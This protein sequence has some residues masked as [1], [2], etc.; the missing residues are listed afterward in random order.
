M[1]VAVEVAFLRRVASPRLHQRISILAATARD[2]VWGVADAVTVRVSAGV[3]G[4]VVAFRAGVPLVSATIV[5]CIVPCI[6]DEVVVVDG[7]VARRTQGNAVVVVRCGIALKCVII[8]T[9]YIDATAPLF[10]RCVVVLEG[11]VARR[12][13]GDADATPV[14]RYIVAL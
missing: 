8:R 1:V 6:V 9:F 2:W 11:V 7:V 3:V 14:A 5:P 13:Q 4:V 10:V 12:T